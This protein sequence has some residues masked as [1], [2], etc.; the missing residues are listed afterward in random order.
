MSSTIPVLLRENVEVLRQGLVLLDRLDDHQFGTGVPA[1]KL[2][3]PG[4]HV[5]HVIDFYRRLL[6]GLGEG[7]I[8]YDRRERDPRIESERSV[9]RAALLDLQARL[10]SIER[11]DRSVAVRC[12][13]LPGASS[14]LARELQG[15]VSHTV[16]HYA[17]IAVAV[18]AHGVEPD[19]AFGV[20]PSTLAY[21]RECVK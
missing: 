6:E 8:D 17:L 14:T 10:Q 11:A 3:G 15:L 12:D 9:C 1:L 4:A 13:Q 21:W 5:R 2:A 18:R 7:D 16:H 19:E 20:A